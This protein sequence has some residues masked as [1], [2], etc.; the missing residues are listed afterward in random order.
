MCVC[1]R[2]CMFVFS[3]EEN[4]GRLPVRPRRGISDHLSCSC[5]SLLCDCISA[6]G[7]WVTEM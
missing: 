6:Q 2:I 7:F 4:G 1:V 5:L 3:R